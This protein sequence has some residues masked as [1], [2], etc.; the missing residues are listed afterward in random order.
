MS[1]D[2]SLEMAMCEDEL[3]R[4]S[5]ALPVYKQALEHY[6]AAIEAFF[7]IGQRDSPALKKCQRRYEQCSARVRELEAWSAAHGAG[8]ELTDAMLRRMPLA[9]G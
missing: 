1:G 5:S 8:E 4:K 9:P 7:S 2:F 6:R 3:G